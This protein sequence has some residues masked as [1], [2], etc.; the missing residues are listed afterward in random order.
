M[1]WSKVMFR[2]TVGTDEVAGIKQA[3]VDNLNQMRAIFDVD[4]IRE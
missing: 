4:V 2:Y 3:P 1:A